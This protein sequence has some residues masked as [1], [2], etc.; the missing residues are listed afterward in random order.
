VTFGNGSRF[1]ARSVATGG[2]S[3]AEWLGWRREFPE[4]DLDDCPGLVLVAPHPDD[5][6]LGLVPPRPLCGLAVSRCRW[7]R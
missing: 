5:E 1:A 3:T 4:L 2:T 7:C 6:T